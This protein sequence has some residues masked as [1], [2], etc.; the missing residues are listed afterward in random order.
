MR[1]VLYL[2]ASGAQ[3]WSH[4]GKSWQRAS[5][6]GA[7]P[8]YLL[9]NLP[10]ESFESVA[11]PR[12]F[13]ADR[14]SFIKRQLAS[15]FADTPYTTLLPTPVTGGLMDHLAPPKQL[16][17]GLEA[18]QRI[19]TMLTELGQVPV[20]GVWA[21]SLLLT[22]LAAHKS[23]PKDLFVVFADDQ[24]LRIVFIKQRVPVLTRLIPAM[25]QAPAIAAEITRTVHYLEN[26][27]LLERSSEP[28]SVLML[29]HQPGLESAFKTD[30][31]IALTPPPPWRKRPPADWQLALFDAVLKAPAGQLA[32]LTWRN[33]FV[34]KRLRVAVYA[35]AGVCLPLA[36]AGAADSLLQARDDDS[37]TQ[38][39]AQRSRSLA[40]QI[41]DIE[42]KIGSFGVT[43]DEVR[44]TILLAQ[45]EL[46]QAPD[47]A[48]HL[49]ALSGVVSAFDG[50]RV[51][52]LA[53]QLVD[54][55]R[56]ACADSVA[57]AALVAPAGGETP[58]PA[59]A[60]P[61]R[62]VEINFVLSDT[63][64]RTERARLK[65]LTGFSA[66]L[67]QVPGLSI[68]AEPTRELAQGSISGGALGTT[69]QVSHTLAWCLA[70]PWPA[71]RTSGATP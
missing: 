69:G 63:V 67:A 70:M 68:K 27:R 17:F 4:N 58:Q 62:E 24:A 10:E 56:V 47:L 22:Q 54:G 2:N 14:Q 71:A 1:T 16:A 59:P 64:E 60:P 38:A 35:L 15:R 61:A 6:A 33:R 34:A 43:V 23:L 55:G 30:N 53:W 19:N 39:M 65:A 41:T 42:Q 52:N 31:L 29:G 49:Q 18:A 5:S 11:V 50:F 7:G 25:T 32:P 40:Q 8:V 46:A 66:Q 9:C 28:R 21:T 37:T 26:S 48:L 13:G 12:I 3:Y 51:R 44:N 57:A 20:A 36:L 45:N